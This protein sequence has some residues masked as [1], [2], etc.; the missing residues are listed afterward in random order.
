MGVRAGIGSEV[1]RVGG[2]ASIQSCN[3]LVACCP[4]TLVGCYLPLMA[5]A[6]TRFD[7]INAIADHRAAPESGLTEAELMGFLGGSA[8]D[9]QAAL[10]DALDRDEVEERDGRYYLTDAGTQVHDSQLFGR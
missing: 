10:K 9:A 1:L 2:R 3:A 7:V 4:Q 5:T 8:E 6:L